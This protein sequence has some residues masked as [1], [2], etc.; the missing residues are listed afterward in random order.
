LRSQELL[1]LFEKKLKDPLPG[2]KAQAFM[3]PIPRPGHKDVLSLEDDHS[4]A[5]VLI[6]LYLWMKRLYVLL[7]KRTERL[8][9]HR[10]QVSFPGGRQEAQEILET[11]AIREASEELGISLDA[12]CILGRLTPLYIPPSNYCVFPFVAFLD[13]RPDFRPSSA[14]VAEIIEVPLDHLLDKDNIRREIWTIRGI[15]IDVPFYEYGEHKIWGA[16]AMIMSEFLHV[17]K[18]VFDL[19]IDQKTE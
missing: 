15:E 17:W 12:S 13:E 18:T 6:L 2:I 16:T 11:T 1:S 10:A 3:M 14:E 7:T 19:E 5:G 9:H 8:Y 4:K